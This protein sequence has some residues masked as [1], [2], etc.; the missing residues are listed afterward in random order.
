VAVTDDG[1]GNGSG[2]SGGHGL[3]GIRE[4]VAVYDG[5]LQAGP[6]PVGGF[7]LRAR[8]PVPSA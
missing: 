4:R 7:R 2:A 5:E 8:L 3:L 6:R 1:R